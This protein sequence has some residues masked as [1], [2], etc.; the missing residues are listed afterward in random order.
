MWIW[1]FCIIMGMLGFDHIVLMTN[2][3]DFIGEDAIRIL[4]RV[5]SECNG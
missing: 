4:L 5:L 2:Q 3:S 1:Q